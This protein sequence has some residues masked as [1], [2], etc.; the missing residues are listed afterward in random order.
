MRKYL[1]LGQGDLIRYLLELLDEELSRP[2]GQIY[3]HNL[4][5]VSDVNEVEILSLRI[6]YLR[7]NVF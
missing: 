7:V 2:A 6:L 5:C 3:P 4:V 1:L